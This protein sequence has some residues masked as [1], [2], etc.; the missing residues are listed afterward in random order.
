LKL[1]FLGDLFYDYDFIHNDI[2][3]LSKFIEDND[4]ITVANLEASL[5]GDK[6]IRKK[7]Y[8]LTH[9]EIIFE[10]LKLLHVK[11]VNIANNHIMDNGI[12][13]FNKL[14]KGLID[15]NIGYFG[16]G[17]NIKEA[18][19]PYYLHLKNKKIGFCGF[20]WKNEDCIYSGVHIPGVAPLKRDILLH[21]IDDIKT[22]NALPVISLHWGYEWEKYPLPIHRKLAGSLI[23]SGAELIIG[24]HP[25]VIQAMEIYRDKKVFYSLGNFYF[26][27]WRDKNQSHKNKIAREYGNIGLGVSWDINNN[28]FNMYNFKYNG[29]ETVV[30]NSHNMDDMSSIKLNDYNSF[31]KHH[32][33]P[34]FLSKRPSLFIGTLNEIINP[35]KVLI[36]EFK[37]YLINKIISILKFLRVY[38]LIKKYKYLLKGRLW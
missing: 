2:Y 24:H 33:K 27:S 34:I 7:L 8:S 23:Q 29:Q 36:S 28:D 26:G 4:F 16:A 31:Y 30:S 22:E 14:T 3:T 21:V 6:L 12:T 20:G 11:V 5:R 19:K 13:G 10:V 32:R 25:H 18:V 9:T 38:D 35:I 37:W 1:L 15:N 17:L